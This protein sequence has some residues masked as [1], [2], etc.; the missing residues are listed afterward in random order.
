[1]EQRSASELGQRWRWRPGPAAPTVWPVAKLV[2]L[3]TVVPL[4]ELYLLLL[5][6]GWLGF[7]PTVGLVLVT[8][9]FGAWLAKREGLRAIE[10]WRSSLSRGQMPEEGVLGGVLLL[11]G[12]VLLVTPGVLTD[13]TG[14]ALLVPASRRR[15]ARWLRPWIHRRIE[16]GVD[17]G[18][19][20]VVHYSTGLG[21]DGPDIRPAA[22]GW[23]GGGLDPALGDRSDAP[24]QVIDTEGRE[25]GSDGRGEDD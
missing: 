20:R 15:I 7:W 23:E 1:M 25:V 9:L 10:R 24:R 13:V 16:R 12:G 5:I 8:G 6:G 21:D 2:L 11:V 19:I 4:V 22:D 14:L 17:A 3:F 18:T